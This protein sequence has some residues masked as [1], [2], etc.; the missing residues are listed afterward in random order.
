MQR[1]H[2]VLLPLF[3]LVAAGLLLNDS[4]DPAA[5][6]GHI[7][8]Q[9]VDAN[10]DALVGANIHVEGTALGA[11]TDRG[12]RY[13]IR[14]VPVGIYTVKAAFVGFEPKAAG[15]VRVQN[16]ATTTVDFTL[17][18]DP[19]VDPGVVVKN[20]RPEARD[21]AKSQHAVEEEIALDLNMDLS[22][23]PPPAMSPTQT[24]ALQLRP[25]SAG[26]GLHGRYAPP[27]DREGYAA[28][29]E[30]DFRRPTDA[31][32]STFS[33]DVDA[34]SYANV[35]RFLDDG[36]MPV[37][38]AVR[39]EELVNYFEY[40]YPDPGG[41]HPFA[42]VA[43]VSEAPWAPEHRLVHIGLQ[44]E[45]IDTEDLPPSN[46]VFLIDVSG[47]MGSPDKLPLLKQAFRLLAS[48]LRP[49]DRVGIVV[50]AGAAGVV[51]EPTNDRAAILDALDRL[52][53]GGST[54]GG[55]GIQLA[56]KLARQHFD[57]EKNNRVILATDG[58]FN[59]GASSDAEMMRLV[60]RERESGVFLSVL[61]FGT[62]NLQDS[63]METIANHG[64]GHYAYIDSRGE[65]RK[66]LVNE[67]G[68]T[69][70]AIA[71]DVKIQVEF[72]PAHVAAYRLVGYENRLLDD[73]DFNDD[74]KDAGE[75]GA[76]HSVT[77]LYE[78]VPVGVEVPTA[79]VDELKYQQQRPD[80]R[81]AASP[82]MLTVKLRYKQPDGDTS[83]LLERALV[84]RGT[85]LDATS[86]AFRFSAAVAQFGLLLRDSGHKAEAS[87][88]NVL[89]LARGA[90]GADAHGY[91]AE[92]IRL[93]ETAEVLSTA[94]VATR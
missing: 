68:G 53:S 49:V 9:V 56:Y 82:E 80:D 25:H 13:L 69:L 54:A 83:R 20:E 14:D 44:G 42:V 85:P 50:Y 72:N 16:N 88:P 90:R 38:D 41:E 10:G 55:A 92:F 17:S 32:L 33:I 73:E 89:A 5:D 51:L 58:D 40:D 19:N 22:S 1:V 45:R 59:V 61:G 4:A 93:V 75:L 27:V 6:T 71:K 34:A 87:Y 28:I 64:N 63:K 52:Q 60:E 47:S 94:E 11:A 65:A 77:A 43:E 67:M 18:A 79:N 84:D 2:L 48:N 7:A 62:G 39:I 8:G 37:K 76:G 78:I 31:P 3:F 86:D 66:V 46:L 23:V 24:R 30:N 12:G 91:R 81:A 74:T 15:T 26:A 35:R 36:R 70:V 29:V 57:A 21:D